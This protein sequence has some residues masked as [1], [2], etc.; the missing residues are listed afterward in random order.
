VRGTLAGPAADP[1]RPAPRVDRCEFWRAEVEVG[2]LFFHRLQQ[3]DP[4]QLLGFV[5]GR[6]EPVLDPAAHLGLEELKTC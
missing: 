1:Q 6:Q 3:A 2:L 5:D 4:T